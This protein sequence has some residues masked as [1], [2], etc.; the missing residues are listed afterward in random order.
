[1]ENP[2]TQAR[3]NLLE[4]LLDEIDHERFAPTDDG[5]A[6]CLVCGAVSPE[7]GDEQHQAGCAFAS[8]DWQAYRARVRN[9]Q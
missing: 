4:R 8:A 5:D 2:E 1:M 7:D 6:V 3:L 9:H